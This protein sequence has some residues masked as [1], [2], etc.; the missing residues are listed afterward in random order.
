MGGDAW[1]NHGGANRYIVIAMPVFFI[2]F[3][4][5]VAELLKKAV[6]QFI[7][8]KFEIKVYGI[9]WRAV[10]VV[11]LCFPFSTSTP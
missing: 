8:N 3:S 6:N 9:L 5:T 11:L 4:W 1:E 2:T 7:T 10:F